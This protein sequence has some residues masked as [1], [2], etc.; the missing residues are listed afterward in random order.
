MQGAIMEL[1]RTF[2]YSFD[3]LVKMMRKNALIKYT[4]HLLAILIGLTFILLDI[5]IKRRVSYVSILLVLAMIAIF[6][7]SYIRMPVKVTRVLK[8]LPMLNEQQNIVITDVFF[9]ISCLS[10][11][12]HL[13]WNYFREIIFFSDHINFCLKSRGGFFIPTHIYTTEEINWLKQMLTQKS[14]NKR[15]VRISQL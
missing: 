3:Q 8:Q 6:P 12:N 14:K 5:L 13:N 4:I 7:I 15:F 9:S 1:T 2:T 11:T 10:S